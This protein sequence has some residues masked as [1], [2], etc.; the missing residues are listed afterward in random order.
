MDVLVII[1]QRATDLI[2]VPTDTG[3][4]NIISLFKNGRRE[5]IA[6]ILFALVVGKLLA[7][8]VNVVI[9]GHLEHNN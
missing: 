1:F 9:T 5:K 3:G 6:S 7:F 8:I 4:T 2:M